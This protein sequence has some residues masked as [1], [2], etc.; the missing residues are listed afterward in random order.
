[1]RM[2]KGIAAPHD[3][4]SSIGVHITW[5]GEGRRGSLLFKTVRGMDVGVELT[6]MYS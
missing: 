3:D 1:M 5:K 6:W 4:N 2:E